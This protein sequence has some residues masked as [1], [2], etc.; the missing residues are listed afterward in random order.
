MKC[1]TS[2]C[3]GKLTTNSIF[4]FLNLHPPNPGSFVLTISLS[5]YLA[6]IIKNSPVKLP[7]PKFTK[8]LY[9]TDSA[10]LERLSLSNGGRKLITCVPNVMY[11]VTVLG[12]AIDRRDMAAGRP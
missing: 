12:M 5:T 4:R 7:E 11:V 10:R 3:I 9:E 2:A 8:V 1:G 6:K